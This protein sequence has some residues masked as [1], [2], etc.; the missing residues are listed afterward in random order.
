MVMSDTVQHAPR[1]AALS[2]GIWF[3][4]A[5]LTSVGVG[6]QLCAIDNHINLMPW[7]FAEHN[8][9]AKVEKTTGQS[10]AS[11]LKHPPAHSK[12]DQQQAR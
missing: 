10:A 2:K 1:A 9:L 8:T 12:T 11:L 5:L 3:G 6:Y 7:L 4:I